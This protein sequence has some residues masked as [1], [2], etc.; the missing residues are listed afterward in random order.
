V[1]TKDVL[2]FVE[3]EIASRYRTLDDTVRGDWVRAVWKAG[4]LETAREVIRELVDDP[5]ATLNVKQFYVRLKSRSVSAAA[6]PKT[7]PAYDPYVM[8]LEAPKDHA[9]WQGLE[10]FVMGGPAKNQVECFSRSHSSDKQY[11]SDWAGAAARAYEAAYGGQW[12]GVVREVD[13]SPY[14]GTMRP[15][16]R[17]AEAE[18]RILDGPDT[19]GRRRLLAVRQGA[20]LVPELK[21]VPPAPMQKAAQREMI[22][23]LQKPLEITGEP[24]VADEDWFNAESELLRAEEQATKEKLKEQGK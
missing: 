11:V 19:L 22:D 24:L 21:V 9:D 15:A 20:A 7:V 23:R 13:N 3:L 1:T 2:D 12:C 4:Q 6:E 16:Q 8:C 18:R 10:W 14:E 5:A 17:R